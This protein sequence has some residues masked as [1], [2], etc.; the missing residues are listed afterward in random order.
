M[1]VPL[2]PGTTTRLK[3]PP[4]CG[5]LQNRTEG[6]GPALVTRYLSDSLGPGVQL[7]LY[8]GDPPK[9]TRRRSL[10]SPWMFFLMAGCG[11]G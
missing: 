1:L 4:R 10:S 7:G 5:L 3:Y 6:L 11:G 9:T 2:V 8:R